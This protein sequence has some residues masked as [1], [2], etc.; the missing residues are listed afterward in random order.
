MRHLSTRPR[1][2]TARKL[3]HALLGAAAAVVLPVAALAPASAAHA[4]DAPYSDPSGAAASW[5]AAQASGDHFEFNGAPDVGATLD[6]LIGLMAAQVGG[7]QVQA[8]LEWINEPDVLSSYVYSGEGEEDAPIALGAAGKVMYVVATAG[9]DPSDFGGVKLAEEVTAAPTEGLDGGTL[10][11]AALG[12]S[13]TEE[14][15]SEEVAAALLAAQCSDGGFSFSVP[16]GGDCASDPD[17]TGLAV[18]ALTAIGEDGAEARGTALQWLQDQ[19]GEDGSFDGGFGANANSTALAAQ[20][21][22]T[23]EDTADAAELSVT[24]LIGLQIGCG[25]DGEGAIRFS[26]P[27][28]PEFGESSRLLATAQALVPLSA[29]NL[30]ELD[31]SDQARDV[32]AVECE[33]A[34]DAGTGDAG[35]AASD[36]D[37]GANAWLPWVIVGAALVLL[38]I[39]AFVIVRARRGGRGAGVESAE[40]KDRE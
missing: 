9:G 35:D 5:L 21:L 15:V 1:R 24:Y 6:S 4:Q 22:L 30:A 11:W 38:A 33:S 39:V 37:D 28:D 2:F 36:E 25:E 13:R 26:D 34:E 29:Q 19:Q 40:G 18:S 12:L 27:E 8:S 17:T 14:G 20:A 23:S 31:A 32:P 3:R 10:S 16:E 7:D